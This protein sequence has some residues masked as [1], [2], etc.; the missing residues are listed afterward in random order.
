MKYRWYV[1]ILAGLTNSILVGLPVM[2]LSVLF[3]EISTA[4]NL[5]VVQV[6]LLWGMGSLPSVFTALFGGAIGD[7]F[8]P[9]RVLIA[10]CLL[11][12][13][14]GALRGAAT[15]FSTLMLAIILM[16]LLVPLVILNNI[17]ICGIWFPPRQLGLANG[18]L[19]MG[20]SLGFILAS[21]FSA[22]VLSPQLGGW[23]NVLYLYGALG[24]LL[25]IP[26]LL[27]N[28]A[29]KH[30]LAFGGT[31][32]AIPMRVAIAHVMRLRMLWLLSLL[33][34]GI[35]GCIQGVLGYL[36][37]YLQTAGWPTLLADQ[38]F[39]AFNLVSLV[40]IIP[41]ALLSDRLGQR[42]GVLLPVLLLLL[43]GVGL[44]SVVEGGLIWVAV[45][46]AGMGRDGFMGLFVTM[47]LEVDGVGV[48]YAGSA[49]GLMMVFLSLGN[50]IAPLVGNSLA[51]T[52]P[53]LPFAL[54]AGLALAGFIGLV[55]VKEQRSKAVLQTA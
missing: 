15:D 7:R 4:L 6:G 16:G 51:L 42:K 34:M 29:P 37:T 35:S 18:V 20:V 33:I 32:S 28:A 27:T 3:P 36:P 53:R 48:D 19:S 1:L 12:G 31:T 21:L 46:I 26:W 40:F 22:S 23:R 5:N 9:K 30:G 24:M 41:I 49:S 2:S 54:W 38:A 47:I 43:T 8:G 50:T 13:A 11:T 55:F 52:D 45:I 10:A 25:A 44:L 17:K 39:S 14:A